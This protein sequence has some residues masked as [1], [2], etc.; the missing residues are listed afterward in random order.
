MKNKKE[1]SIDEVAWLMFLD[2]PF[3]EVIG[4]LSTIDY[5]IKI[6]KK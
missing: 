5:K 3:V 1:M 2:T 6:V 4:F